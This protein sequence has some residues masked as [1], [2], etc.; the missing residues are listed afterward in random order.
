MIINNSKLYIFLFFINLGYSQTTVSASVDANRI[1]RNET[2][3]LKIIATNANGTPSVNVSPILKDFKI[4]SGPAQQTNIQWINGAMT[5]SRS[6][7]WTL[8]AKNEGKINIPSLEVTVEKNIYRTNPIGITVEKGAGRAQ[9]ANVFIEAKSDKEQAYPGEQI[10]VTYRLFTRLNLSIEDIEYP[11]S[12]GF[13]NEDLRVAQTIRF[14]NTKIKGIDYKV[15]TLYKSALFPTQSGNL[16]IAPMTAICN[17]E[18]PSRGKSNNFFNDAFFNSMFK[19]TQRQF[20]QSDSINIKVVKYPITPPTDFSGAVGKFE[21]SSWVDTPN[22]KINE[23]ITFKLKLKG[24]G[25]LNQFNINNINFPQ[26][27]EVFPPTSSFKREEFRDD[28]TGEQNFEYI[29]IPRISGQFILKPVTLTYFDPSLQKFIIA[30][31]NPVPLIINNNNKGDISI[32]QFNREDISLLSEDIRHIKKYTPR[33]NSKGSKRIP[34]W[35][36]G[37][38]VFASALF[39]FPSVISKYNTNRLSTSS[40]RQSRGALKVALTNLSK[41]TTDPFALTSTVLY[42][43]FQSKLYLS[44]ENLDPLMIESVLNN[45]IS[46]S[47]LEEVVSL[48]KICDAGRFGPEADAQV[49]TLQIQANNILKKIDKVLV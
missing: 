29:L 8:L 27:M 21:I 12:V 11:K 38:Y 43:Y 22:V 13:W 49:E 23:A 2:I 41:S 44:S 39:L 42:K 18:K 9:M 4:I 47:L 24:T 32:N 28:L 33:L 36:W 40:H 30:R 46:A 14:N 48:A 34:I 10:T 26:N 35:V 16:V 3:G 6:L 25:N 1:S 20:I 15:A 17:V 7:S 31:S 5:S 19:E 37:T 45:K